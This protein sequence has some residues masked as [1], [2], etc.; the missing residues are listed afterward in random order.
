[1]ALC[2]FSA[3]KVQ[4]NSFSASNLINFTHFPKVCNIKRKTSE[5]LSK[6]RNSE[7]GGGSD[8]NANVEDDGRIELAMSS[9]HGTEQGN[10][11]NSINLTKAVCL[12]ASL[13]PRLTEIHQHHRS[14][15]YSSQGHSLSRFQA[16]KMWLILK[17]TS[18]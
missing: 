14:S 6:L 17:V 12:N 8:L 10:L 15:S 5:I 4:K 18:Q 9:P 1:M 13:L 11:S 2:G 3:F 16:R 7:S